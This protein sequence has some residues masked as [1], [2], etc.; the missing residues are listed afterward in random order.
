LNRRIIFKQTGDPAEVLELEET[1]SPEPG[2]GQ[3]K[4]RLK[5]API[6]P[7][8]I[9]FIQGV[10]GIKP[11][12]PST[13]GFE[14]MATVETAAD[15]GSLA[16]G[17]PVIPLKSFH[18]WQEEVVCTE[19]ECLALPDGI[20]PEQASML[21][22]N[23]MTAYRMLSDFAEL[24]PGDAIAHNAAN[25]G[26]GTAVIQLAKHLGLR[27]INLVRREECVEELKA[28]GADE[29]VV[30]SDDMTDQLKELA[31][32]QGVKLALNAV[33]GESA[34]A[35][36]KILS[37]GGHHVTYGAM[38][39]KPV[40]LPNGLLIFKQPHFHGFW[41]TRW[42]DSAPVEEVREEYRKLGQLVADG[43]IRIP[44]EKS[45]PLDQFQEAVTRAQEE[46]RQGK[47]L[48]R[49]G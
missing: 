3:L 1:A 9:N 33:G 32:R 19:A 49:M 12:L 39:K 37:P 41:L 44:V 14:G 13:V 20:D 16:K 25:S 5:A 27:S 15:G 23:P 35:V 40:T 38:S 43:I 17:T 4:L 36:A 34:L 22:V 29:V 30:E 18:T 7:S 8:D 42:V 46:K 47:I 21:S 10:Y 11:E 6:N 24:E 2:E 48:F 28:L 45:F 26:V 31:G